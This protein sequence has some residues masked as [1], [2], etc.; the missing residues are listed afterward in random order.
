MNLSLSDEQSMLAESVARFI[1]NDYDFE[2]RQQI[3][4]EGAGYSRELWQTYAELGWTAVPFA[5]DDGGLDG[6]P[7]ELV[8]MMEQFGR[9]LV[10]EP[11]LATIVLAGGVLRRSASAQQR[12]QWL[13]GIIEGRT[14]AA[15]AFT[16]PQARFEIADVA[17]KAEANG[18]GF[19]LN[20]RKKL[21][22]N[23]GNADLLII[24]ARTH[25]AQSDKKG[26]TLFAV[27]ADSAGIIRKDYQTVD[28]H[29]AAD[30]SLKD[31]HVD[32][33]SI[34]GE[35]GQGFPVLEAVI[36]E[37]ILAV[38][39]EAVGILRTLH[40][41]TVEYAKNRVQFGVPI[42][43]FQALQHRMVDMLVACEQTRSL[44]LWTAMVIADGDKDAHRAI[45]A[46]KYQIGTAGRKVAQ[47]AIQIHGAMGVT[48]ELDISHYFK[49]FTAIEL[50]FGNADFHL[51]RYLESS[52]YHPSP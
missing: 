31:V 11:Y 47:E 27:A 1:D 37:A 33:Q 23:G 41:K 18:N 22:L 4:E 3:A 30:I 50:L 13:S 20:G 10:V 43:S 7:I 9:G 32:S 36:D 8:L 38:C 6:G 46:L 2:S 25:G 44:L 49:R 39:A 12:E 15:L 16:E 19:I 17:T 45:S 48:W 29:H 35:V 42:G 51:D 5:G 34:L 28:A 52:D 26:I 40:D 14:Q 21:V 24:P